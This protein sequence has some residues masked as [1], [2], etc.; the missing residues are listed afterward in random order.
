MGLHSLQ[1]LHGGL[2]TLGALAEHACQPSGQLRH[3]QRITACQG[4]PHAL[5]GCQGG[6]ITGL[7]I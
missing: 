5:H 2:L 7:S 3:V 1:K 6:V 4:C